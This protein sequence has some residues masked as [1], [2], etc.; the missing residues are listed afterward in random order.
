[1]K[2]EKKFNIW[3]DLDETLLSA[4]TTQEIDEW[5][6][7]AKTK[8]QKIPSNF[9]TFSMDNEYVIFERPGLQPFLDYL[10]FNFNVSVWTAGSQEYCLSIVD[11]IILKPDGW[12]LHGERVLKHVFWSYHCK[13]SIRLCGKIKKLSLLSSHFGLD[14][15]YND[16]NTFI[17]DD[18]TEVHEANAK[19]VFVIKPFDVEDED[20][21]SD[22]AFEKIIHTLNLLLVS[23][24]LP[25]PKSKHVINVRRNKRQ[26]SF[27][28]R[29]SGLQRGPVIY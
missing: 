26:H 24:V 28:Q 6:K 12:K 8:G 17:I 4:K 1:M 25:N 3:L 23:N 13:E 16:K 14:K 27:S 2:K 11:N 7:E 19:N 29:R 10:F 20:A 22:L 21:S 9:K 5:K 18:N 15:E